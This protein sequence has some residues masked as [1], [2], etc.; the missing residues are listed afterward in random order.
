MICLQWILNDSGNQEKGI[1]VVIYAV[2]CLNCRYRLHFA[3][4]FAHI[5]HEKVLVQSLHSVCS[6][7]PGQNSWDTNPIARQIEASS[8]PPSPSV[9]YWRYMHSSFNSTPSTLLG[10]EGESRNSPLYQ[11]PQAFL[12]GTTRVNLAKCVF[13]PN[14]LKCPK[15]FWPGL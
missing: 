14:F 9:Q 2:V 10:G 1:L 7:N 15:T 8:L 3:C 13:V 6:Y 4:L 5:Y 12:R 11:H